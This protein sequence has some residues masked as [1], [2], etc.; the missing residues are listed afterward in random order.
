MVIRNAFNQKHKSIDPEYEINF[1][2][3][4][5]F[6]NMKVGENFDLIVEKTDILRS[7]RICLAFYMSWLKGVGAVALENMFE[8]ALTVEILRA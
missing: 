5:V 3:L 7:I 2:E 4:L 6:E 1:M 8:D